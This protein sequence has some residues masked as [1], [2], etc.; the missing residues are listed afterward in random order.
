MK[1]TLT[2]NQVTRIEVAHDLWEQGQALGPRTGYLRLSQARHDIEA[3]LLSELQKTG[4][5]SDHLSIS[6]GM[7]TIITPA[8]YIEPIWRK[9]R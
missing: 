9:A 7:A 1:I 3:Q 5:T 6:H 4:Y 8:G 2:A